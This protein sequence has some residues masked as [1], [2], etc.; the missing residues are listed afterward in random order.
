MPVCRRKKGRSKSNLLAY[1]FIQNQLNTYLLTFVVLSPICPLHLALAVGV[2]IACA[3]EPKIDISTTLAVIPR[4]IS[5][6]PAHVF[7]TFL[8]DF[9]Q[10]LRVIVNH[11]VCRIAFGTLDRFYNYCL[12]QK[13]KAYQN[14]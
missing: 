6:F 12:F 4:C 14:K 7:T 5:P 9:A 8:H 10:R 11:D 13:D 1:V 3:S 2:V